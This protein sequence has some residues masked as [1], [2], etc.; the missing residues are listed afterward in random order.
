MEESIYDAI[1]GFSTLERVHKIFYDKIYEHPWLKKFFEGF[2]QKVI[3][4]KQ[5]TFMGEKFGG[6]A[7]TGKSIRQ[8]H[9]NMFISQELADLRH[10]ILHESLI[11]AG[12]SEDIQIRWLRVDAAF[13]KQVIKKSVESFYQ[14]YHFTY[15]QRIFHLNPDKSK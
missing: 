4:D 9:E 11:E 5:S 12:I 13:M 2:D 3:E 14:D 6:P 7:Y 8:V 10:K 15:K 1:G